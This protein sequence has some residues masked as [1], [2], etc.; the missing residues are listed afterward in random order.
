MVAG[1]GLA[2]DGAPR[3]RLSGEAESSL[4][5]E[6]SLPEAG[7]G[8]FFA[9]FDPPGSWPIGDY[10]VVLLSG[11]RELAFWELTI[12]AEGASIPAAAE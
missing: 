4:S 5:E 6:R 8:P 7:E 2:A 11:D 9:R 12:R 3:L 10:R 1:S